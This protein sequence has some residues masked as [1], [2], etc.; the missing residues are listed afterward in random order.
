MLS[1]HPDVLKIN[2]G[3]AADLLPDYLTRIGWAGSTKEVEKILDRYCRDAD[4]ILVDLITR[5]TIPPKIG[6]G[7]FSDPTDAE[8][9]WSF[10]LRQWVRDG[11]CSME[12]RD[13]LLAWPGSSHVVYRDHLWPTLMRRKLFFK[14]VYRPDRPLEV[15][16]YLGFIP[17]FSLI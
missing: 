4:H 11:L 8:I 16:A 1:R 14:L 10:L 3:T 15:K 12:E 6:I 2:V 5:D 9:G 13:A 7:L 17:C